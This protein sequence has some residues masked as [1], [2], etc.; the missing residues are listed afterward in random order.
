MTL[1]ILLILYR[2]KI[3][4]LSESKLLRHLWDKGWTP[5]NI[6]EL[7]TYLGDYA[8]RV[9]AQLLLEEFTFGFRIQYEG[10]RISTTAKNLVSAEIH[11][12]ETLAK[13]HDEVKLGRILGPFSKKPISTL[14]I[15]PIGLV[16]KPDNGWRLIS[17]LSYPSG[18]DPFPYIGP[19]SRSNSIRH[20]CGV[21]HGHFGTE[22]D[23]L[24][25]NSVAPST[26]KLYTRA[27]NFFNSFRKDIGLANVWPVSLH[28]IVAFIAYMYKSGFAHSTINSYTSG[29][30]FYNKLNDYE[31]YTQ[32]FIV[33]K[34]ID[35]VKRTRSP[36]MD[37]RLP[38]S[39]ELLG[40]ILSILSCICSSAY[41]GQRTL[42]LCLVNAIYCSPKQTTTNYHVPEC[43]PGCRIKVHAEM[44]IRR[45]LKDDA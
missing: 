13:L 2:I 29:L 19:G 21:S 17:H 3:V 16:Q 28:D 37:T 5:I 38:I 9:D 40:R 7:N 27:L 45:Q 4:L 43:V 24:I 26:A 11:K 6:I 15:S 23:F 18:G 32:K 10:P 42:N 33:R 14:R 30:S 44:I 36:Q 34:M 12:F 35:G 1:F 39:R 8:N 20:S 41:E 31:D 22:V 25:N